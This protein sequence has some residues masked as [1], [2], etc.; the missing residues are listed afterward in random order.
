[1]NCLI[2]EFAQFFNVL[3][4]FKGVLGV[5]YSEHARN[6]FIDTM[7]VVILPRKYLSG[8][9]CSHHTLEEV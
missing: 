9:F 7:I 6:N 8:S 1:M 3:A 2:D 4:Y 5:S